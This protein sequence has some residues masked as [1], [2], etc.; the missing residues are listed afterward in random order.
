MNSSSSKAEESDGVIAV[1]ATGLYDGFEGYRTATAEDYR[2]LFS[3]GLVVPD[4]N[5]LLN[6]YRYTGQARD[7]LLSVLERLKDQLWIPHQ[8]LAEFWRNRGIVLRDP[9]DTEKVAREMSDARDRALSS[10]RAWA[11]RV[12]L[13]SEQSTSLAAALNEGFD[14]VIEGVDRFT[15]ASAAESARDTDK[16]EVLKRLEP[17]LDGR[18]GSVLGDAAHEQAVEEGLRRVAQRQPP[19]YMDK[20]KDDDGAAGDFLVWEQVMLEAQQR[21]CDVVFVTGD[22]KEDWWRREGGEQ[23]GPR[24]ELVAEM[25]RRA[26]VRLFMLRPTSL[27]SLAREVLAVTVQ[28]ES[29][30]NAERVD[31]LLSD[32]DAVLPDGGW[33]AETLEK[34]LEQLADE[35][36]TQ[37]QVIVHAVSHGGFVN[38]DTVYDIGGYDE[39]RSLR[40]FTRPINRIARIFRDAGQVDGSAVDL[41]DAVYSS[42]SD[43]PNVAVGFEINPQVQ[44]LLVAILADRSM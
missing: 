41:L 20:K 11:N 6:L 18:V 37:E 8:V 30:E 7:D 32:Q 13:P 16:D 4:A 2:R 12:S 10:F 33:D 44:P 39:D 9:R 19:G 21:G 24:L 35:A 31:R 14:A 5:V 38:R 27:L 15:D 42:T 43:N 23:R 22:V 29:V 40:G 3:E 26:S 36:K 34:L 1:G 25:R 28:D 17:I